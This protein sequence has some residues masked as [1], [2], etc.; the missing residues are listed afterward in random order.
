MAASFMK[1]N[2]RRIDALEHIVDHCH[3][4]GELA[5]RIGTP[6]ILANNWEAQYALIRCIEVIGEAST[7]LGPQFYREHP[8]IPWQL[9]KGMRNGLIHGYDDV[10][11]ERLWNTVTV[12][13]P[14]LLPTIEAILRAQESGKPDC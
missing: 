7:R 3:K 5:M 13:V 14:V 11:E 1:L 10:N 6:E 12:D 9:T 4:A 2:Q 8:E